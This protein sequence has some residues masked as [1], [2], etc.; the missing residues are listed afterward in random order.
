MPRP[1]ATTIGQITTSGRQVTRRVWEADVL[2]V[3]AGPAGSAVAMQLAVAD[4]DVLLVDRARFPRDKTCGDGLTPRAVKALQELGV[5]DKVAAQAHCV[6]GA[7]LFSPSGYRL[8]VNFADYLDGWPHFGLTIPR[9]QLDDT[10]REHA[11]AQGARFLPDCKVLGPVAS[12]VVGRGDL[13]GQ[14]GGEP[15][16]LRAR[17][18]IL[19]TGVN[20][21]LLRAWGF[22]N[23]MP[24]TVSAARAYWE[25]VRDPSEN[26]EFY[27]DRRLDRGYAW[28]FPLGG[29]RANIGLGLFPHGRQEPPSAARE[30]LPFLEQHPALAQRLQGARRAGPVKGYPLRTDFP[31]HPVVRDGVMLV[32]EACGLV[33]PVTGEGI[34][35]ALE[36]G[37][38]AAEVADRALRD[39]RPNMR[40]LS[41]YERELRARFARFFWEMRWMVR[42]AMRPRALD[43]LIRQSLRHSELARVIIH[44][45]LGFVLPHMAFT[46]QVWRALLS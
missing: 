44:I 38:L 6:T 37:L 15:C 3:G 45:T 24:P 8:H 43:I 30:L 19:A 20:L 25:G 18:V 32:G 35:L 14:C 36:S 2:V 39:G 33:N 34:D 41:P 27:F 5:L 28:L 26:F 4:W 23:R 31:R 46:P 42:L 9:F 1:D 12:D 29:G 13:L 17:L 40:G 22:V 21:P 10:L 16:L 11:R 7:D